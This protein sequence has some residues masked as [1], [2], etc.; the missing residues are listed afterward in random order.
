MSLT[1]IQA[2]RHVLKDTPVA[3]MF[4]RRLRTDD[5]VT[6]WSAETGQWILA[7]WVDKR[8]KLVDE[9]EDLGMAFEKVTP[10]LTQQIVSCWGSVDLKAK[11]KRLLSK[12]RDR[13]RKSRDD[14]MSEQ[15]RWDWAQKK[16]KDKNIN[17]VPY[18][19]KARIRGGDVL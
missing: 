5:I 2:D 1:T 13:L 18:A 19:F 3:R 11:K 12:E 14:V 8:V 10:E 16:M 9:V 4:R 15:D 6:F 7:Y 17:P